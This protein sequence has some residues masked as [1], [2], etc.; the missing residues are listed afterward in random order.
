ML[1]FIDIPSSNLP[2]LIYNI[3]KLP[4][5]HEQVGIPTAPIPVPWSP[6][7]DPQF[8]AVDEHVEH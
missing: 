6:L 5:V 2:L 3:K 4:N 8:E 7:Q 1:Q